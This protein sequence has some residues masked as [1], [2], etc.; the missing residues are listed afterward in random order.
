M[1]EEMRRT[2]QSLQTSLTDPV[3]RVLAVPK[4]NKRVQMV[5]GVNAATTDIIALSDDDAIWTESFLDWC[6]APFDDM[7]TG[8]VGSKQ[9]TI[10]VGAYPSFWEVR[11]TR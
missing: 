2:C 9:S 5:T 11:T 1:E 4:P 8:G 7:K 6:L 10:P 3:F